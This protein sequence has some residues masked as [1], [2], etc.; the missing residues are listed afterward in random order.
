M[1]VHHNMTL[2]NEVK[3][4]TIN[5]YKI[6]NVVTQRTTLSKQVGSKQ[7]HAVTNQNDCSPQHDTSNEVKN[8]TIN[9][10]TI[11][12]QFKKGTVTKIQVQHYQKQVDSK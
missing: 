4:K 1:T 7:T 9:R 5:R 11:N 6:N 8:I 12:Q 10:C 3:N 2:Q